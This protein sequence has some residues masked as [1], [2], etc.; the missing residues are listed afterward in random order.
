[1]GS[2]FLPKGVDRCRPELLAH[3]VLLH[4]FNYR[5]HCRERFNLVKRYSL[6]TARFSEMRVRIIESGKMM[7]PVL[8]EFVAHGF[9]PTA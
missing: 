6:R 5:Q 4:G 1:M 8:A 2:A 3:W 9:R 7:V